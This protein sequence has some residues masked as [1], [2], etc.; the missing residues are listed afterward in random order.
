MLKSPRR[1]DLGS[2]KDNLEDS[3]VPQMKTRMGDT[4]RK[5]H[6]AASAVSPGA[7]PDSS[8]F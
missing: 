8:A 7:G 5:R 3:F 4:N 6:C 2:S 1:F